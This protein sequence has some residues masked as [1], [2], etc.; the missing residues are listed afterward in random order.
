L[1]RR[2]L[3]LPFLAFLLPAGQSAAASLALRWTAP[4]DDGKIGTAKQYDIRYS[5]SP[6]TESNWVSAIQVTGEPTPLAAGTQQRIILTGL[7]PG[8]NYY[9]AMKTADE[10]PNWSTLSNVL[11]KATCTGD[12]VG[13]TGNVNGSTDDRVDLADLSLLHQYL[14]S[15][16]ISEA[17]CLEN[18]N[19]NGSLDGVVDLADLSTMLGYLIGITPLAPCP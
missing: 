11:R 18:A 15:V 3:L 17:I 5:T 12:C 8:I 13:T 4:G 16:T 7:N 9:V 2:L 14:L 1:T 19:C 10:I 6:I